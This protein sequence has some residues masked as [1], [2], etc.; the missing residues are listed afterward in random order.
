MKSAAFFAYADNYLTD[1]K[2][3][4]IM[5]VEASRAIRQAEVGASR[6]LCREVQ[7]NLGH[8]WFCGLGFEG[9]IPDH[10]VFSR[11]RNER[12]P[13]CR[14]CLNRGRRNTAFGTCTQAIWADNGPI[15][16][17]RAET[18]IG[19]HANSE[20]S[21]LNQ[22]ISGGAPMDGSRLSYLMSW[23][24]L[25]PPLSYGAGVNAA[26]VRRGPSGPF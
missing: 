1:V 8:R 19:Y 23:S 17:T 26:I 11:A 5:D 2:F 25:L 13:I 6:T 9:K 18:G 24:R 21:L 16:E 15:P 12:L 10:S 7:V 3:G 14:R 20:Q 4:I 22:F